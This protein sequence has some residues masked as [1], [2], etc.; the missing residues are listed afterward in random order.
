MSFDLKN[1]FIG[2]SKMASSPA[3]VE[4]FKFET[5]GT[6]FEIRDKKVSIPMGPSE[7]LGIWEERVKFITSVASST[8]LKVDD[9]VEL[10]KYHVNKVFYG[11]TYP[12][13]IE[14][15]LSE[16]VLAVKKKAPKTKKK[17]VIQ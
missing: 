2:R 16:S 6:V 5:P 11:V 1:N 10:S 8:K 13:D 3:P 7:N 4:V 17:I 9:I 12:D 15:R 14:R